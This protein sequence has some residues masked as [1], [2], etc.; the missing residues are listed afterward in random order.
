MIEYAYGS[1]FAVAILVAF[2]GMFLF[3]LLKPRTPRE[4]KNFGVTQAFFVALF[5][6]MFGYPL[7]IYVL[8]AA[9]GTSLSF[10]HVEGHLLGVVLG[11]ATGMGSVFGWV[12]VMGASI[13]LIVTGALLVQAG[14][15]AIY[16]GRGGL[17]TTGPYAFVRHPQYLGL[18]LIVLGF[19][20]QWPTIIT[21][22]MAPVLFLAYLRLAKREEQ[23]I[24]SRFPV[25]Y[26]A[27]SERVQA[28]VPRQRRREVSS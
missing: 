11:N 23:D 20:V 26:A 3:S 10:G 14:W 7:T 27:Y 16:G 17:V 22:A 8:S 19:M 15:R 12:L 6:E 18:M 28:F 21:L 5:A 25:E 1:W 2:A 24:R 9:S 4:W 13:V